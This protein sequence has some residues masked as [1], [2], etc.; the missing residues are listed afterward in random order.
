MANNVLFKQGT[1]TTYNQIASKD[2]FTFYYVTD[3]SEGKGDLY[4]GELLLSNNDDLEAAVARLT[5]A[6]TGIED[7]EKALEDLKGTGEGSV[8]E[9]LAALEKKLQ[10]QITN[11]G[12]DLSDAKTAY[13]TADAALDK[14]IG[15]NAT[16]ISNLSTTVDSNKTALEAADA[17][18]LKKI[19]KNADDIS[20]N[21]G[22]INAL[23]GE[24]SQADTDLDKR[25]DDAEASIATLVGSV[26]GDDAKSVRTIATEE[27]TKIVDG[28]PEALDTLKEIADWITD[29]EAGA[30][31]I[32]ADVAANAG[33][34]SALQAKD[35]ELAGDISDNAT[36]IEGLDDRLET[37]EG[38]IDALQ[39]AVST[40]NDGTD[41]ILA[42]AKDYTDGE[43][44][45]V[46]EAITDEAE[47]RAS[48]DEGL[49]GQIDDIVDTTIP[50]ITGDIS[51]INQTI[52]NLQT[53][54]TT[55]YATKAYAD[56]A[57]T[58]AIA[59]AKSYTDGQISA[60]NGN[61]TDINTRLTWQTMA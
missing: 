55:D 7:L 30:A 42:K 15:E 25:L 48:A 46:E 49:Q 28:A 14:K 23:R 51:D 4:L 32:I 41:G 60:V 17:D 31:K 5:E 44:D 24:L 11:L 9:Q 54:L 57:E 43:I 29:D 20:T 2:A 18:L 16:A 45:K 39:Q 53:Q 12:N 10:D 34:I 22:A 19:N 58:D 3:G 59:S 56:Q 13:Q 40:I 33:A 6:E 61:I 50:G 47:A 35:T 21:A 36:A 52:Q 37:A 26:E 8:S 27:V 1:L 38:E